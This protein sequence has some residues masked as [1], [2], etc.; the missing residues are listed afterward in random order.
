M[1]VSRVGLIVAIVVMVPIIIELRTVFVHLG[2]DISLAE[3]AL[4]G[5]F[6]IGLLIVWAITPDIRGQKRSNGE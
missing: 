4:L 2:L 3:T 5:V 1:R 6:L